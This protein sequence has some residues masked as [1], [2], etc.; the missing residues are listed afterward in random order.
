MTGIQI[1]TMVVELGPAYWRNLQA[2]GRQRQLL[3]PD[4]DSIISVAGAMPKKLPT[5]KQCTRLSQIK[6]RLEEEGYPPQ[7]A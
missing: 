2:W 7:P 1:Q 4:E 3:S 5:E 6:R